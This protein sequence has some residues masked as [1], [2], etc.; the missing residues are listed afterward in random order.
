MPNRIDETFARLRASG[1]K[2]FIA[3]ITAGDPNLRTTKNIALA[4]EKCGVDLL[5]LGIPFSDPLADG[6]VNQMAAQ[7]AL[8]SGTTLRGILQ[9]V[10]EIRAQSQL[11]IVFFTYLNPIYAF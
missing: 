6:I 9:I 4:L 1:Q 8:E 10:R 3:F 2:G 11:P 7:R 5:E